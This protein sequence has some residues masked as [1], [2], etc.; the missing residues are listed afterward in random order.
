MQCINTTRF[1]VPLLI[2]AL[3]IINS[4]INVSFKR[5]LRIWVHFVAVMATIALWFGVKCTI[6]DKT[7]S[8]F[9]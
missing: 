2:S 5:H 9:V 1:K 4:I 7:S 3:K 8:R 6:G